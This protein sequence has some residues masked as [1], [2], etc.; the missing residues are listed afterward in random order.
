MSGGTAMEGASGPGSPSP[1]RSPIDAGLVSALIER[2]SEEEI[3]PRFR[4]LAE[5]D[6]REK[7]RGELVTVV[8]EAVERRLTEALTALLPGSLVVG[9]EAIADDPEGLARLDRESDVWIVDPIDGTSNFSRGSETF[10]VMVALVRTGRLI[11]GWIY[12]PAT[13]RMTQ[14]EQG[15]G[16]FTDGERLSVAPAGPPSGMLGSLSAGT[17]GGRELRQT[18]DRNR[19]RVSAIRTLRCAGLEYVRMA[20]GET[21]FALFSRIHPWDHAPGILIHGEAGG[22]TRFLDG[23]GYDPRRRTAPGLLAAPDPDA[24]E[25][26]LDTLLAK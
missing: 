5:G 22:V 12:Q 21:H 17:F 7:A 19:A 13:G 25:G 20:S 10:A 14:A 16:A 8:D 1:I 23:A 18:L 9:E 26:L 15:G 6:I 11:G 2:I 3:R 4:N 24:W